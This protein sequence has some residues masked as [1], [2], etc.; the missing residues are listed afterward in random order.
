LANLKD[1][2]LK[3]ADLRSSNFNSATLHEASLGGADLR[4][5][6]LGNAD[7]RNARGLKPDQVKAAT[8]WEHAHYSTEFR[9]ELGLP[10]E[11]IQKTP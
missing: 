10:P 3:R 2:K 1:T 4:D 5:A 6:L 11:N 7:L 8:R 9:A